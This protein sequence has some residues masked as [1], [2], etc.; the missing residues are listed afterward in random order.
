MKH[1]AAPIVLLLLTL[2][3]CAGSAAATQPTITP[4][5][6]TAPVAVATLPASQL[7]TPPP[8]ATS[9]ATRTPTRTPV[10][11]PTP[12]PAPALTQRTRGCCVQ[13]FFSPDGR[14]VLFI[15]KPDPNAAA[16]IYGLYLAQPLA[17][18]ALVYETIGFYNPDMDI[19]AQVENS[20]MV[21][22]FNIATG[23][24]W[25]V[26]TGGNWPQFSPDSTQITWTAADT[27]G[28]YDRRQN[29]IWLANLD[30]SQ[31]RLVR[32]L[33]G[34]GLAGWFP[35]GEQILV[36]GRDNPALEDVTLSVLN[37][38]T[39]QQTHLFQQKRIR[40]AEIS[41]GG[42]WV[43]FYLT[44]ADNPTDNGVWVVNP[45]GTV[46]QKL[47]TPGFGAYRWRT[48][49]T[50]LYIP[51]RISPRDSMQFW[52]I[53]VAANTSRPLT[54]PVQL[55]FAIAN[56]DWDVSPDGRRVVF[57]NSADQNIWLL[58]LF[59]KKLFPAH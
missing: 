2:T 36:L 5:P 43:I 45:Q 10:P 3:A 17:E 37:L 15:D 46:R 53:D 9:T 34:G 21:R 44:F 32:T 51:M 12:T 30:G 40:G 49:S 48:D 22:F 55:S 25:T 58:T 6:T 8:M 41:P 47:N 52:E 11:S 33:Y 23:Q 50:L 20:D 26:N 38:T 31:A 29:D 35:N 7:D 4:M 18:P 59:E 28:P 57:V 42:S 14:Q 27:E 16:G 19:V 54:N 56:G 1:L 39:G 24:S 13:P